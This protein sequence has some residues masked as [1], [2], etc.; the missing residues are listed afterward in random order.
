M[1]IRSTLIALA[2]SAALPG[3]ALAATGGGNGHQGMKDRF[4]RLD[5][6]GNGRVDRDEFKAGGKFLFG[7]MD[8]DGDGVITMAELED[9][10]RR[11]RIAK[12]FEHMDADADGQVTTGEFAKAGAKL[13][14]RLDENEDGYLSKG[15]LEKRRHGGG[16]GGP[17]NGP[18]GQN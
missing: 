17:D 18:E 12:R 1:K 16:K 14:E 11:E 5:Q 8:V 7:K 4:G 15:E 3:I 2:I 9:H 10:E 6:D 13:F